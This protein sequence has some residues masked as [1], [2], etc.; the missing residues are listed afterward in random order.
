MTDSDS[1][2]P[3]ETA[4][5]VGEPLAP[6]A[7]EPRTPEEMAADAELAPQD[8]GPGDDEPGPSKRPSRSQRLQRKVQ[9][10]TAEIEE[11]RRSGAARQSD[12]GWAHEDEPPHESDFNGDFLG[13]ER[14]LN[15]FHVRQATRDAVRQEA[16]R[17]RGER[18]AAH[19]AEMQRERAIAHLDRVDEI[20]E[21]VADFEETVNAAA[22]IKLRHE[23]VD[24]ILG[25]EKSA[26]IQY[27]L[28]KN[29]EKAHELNGL[30]GRELARAIGRLEGAVRLPA[31]RATDAAPPVHPL[32]GAAMP[33]FDPARAE[34]DAY[35]AN[36][37]A[38][39]RRLANA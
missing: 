21:R 11:M 36:F 27:H 30:T 9:L 16:E 31:R 35:V 37:A 17:A 33:S 18:A 14:A 39:K 26:L 28:A 8:A 22:G 34:M 13:Y 5:A 1:I 12:A 10:L 25:S 15:A 20:K 32:S 19:Q 7:D 38:R 4:P 2:A 23:V 24:E 3:A 29:H 6:V